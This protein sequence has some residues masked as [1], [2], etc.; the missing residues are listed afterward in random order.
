MNAMATHEER[1]HK[2]MEKK[3][4][5]ETAREEKR[6]L[7]EQMKEQQRVQDMQMQQQQQMM[8]MF[9]QNQ[10]SFMQM[11]Q[12]TSVVDGGS[13]LQFSTVPT[14]QAS[15]SNG[16]ATLRPGMGLHGQSSFNLGVQQGSFNLGQQQ[17]SFRAEANANSAL[18]RKITKSVAKLRE[19]KP[20]RIAAHVVEMFV[21]G[22]QNLEN[23]MDFTV[24]RNTS[25]RL[26]VCLFVW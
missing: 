13:T 19:A 25:R 26:F 20:E 5:E 21:T 17:G 14:K 2:V 23:R 22:G 6:V 15:F 24:S 18:K 16:G 3:R 9:M 8:Q 4:V 12:T 11:A 7:K 1:L 10:R